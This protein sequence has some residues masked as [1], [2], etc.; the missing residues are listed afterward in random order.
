M[1]EKGSAYNVFMGRSEGNKPL[2]IDTKIIL[3][4]ILNK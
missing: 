4:W 1:G 3:R 2:S